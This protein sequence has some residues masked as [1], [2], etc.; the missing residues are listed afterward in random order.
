VQSGR[1]KGAAE[2]EREV[3][4]GGAMGWAGAAGPC[5]IS[6]CGQSDHTDG[7]EWGCGNREQS[8]RK[9]GNESRQPMAYETEGESA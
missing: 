3:K 5:R 6:P 4:G 2:E 1:R 9:L 7:T 8:G